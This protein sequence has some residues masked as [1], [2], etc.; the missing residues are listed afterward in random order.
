MVLSHGD[1]VQ[2]DTPQNL[3]LQPNLPFAK[4]IADADRTVNMSWSQEVCLELLLV[5]HSSYRDSGIVLLCVFWT[6]Q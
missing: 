2:F 3:M 1:I 6:M 5:K 4:M